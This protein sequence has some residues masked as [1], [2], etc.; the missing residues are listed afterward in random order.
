MAKCKKCNTDLEEKGK[1]FDGVICCDCATL[2]DIAR[3]VA[4][5]AKKQNVY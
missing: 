5:I 1:D 2:V 3:C 4:F